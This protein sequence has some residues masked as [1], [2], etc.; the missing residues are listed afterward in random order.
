MKYFLFTSDPESYLKD[1]QYDTLFARTSK[2]HAPDHWMYIGEIDFDDSTD[3][4]TRTQE[5]VKF[6]DEAILKLRAEMQ[7]QVDQLETRKAN[8]LSLEYIDE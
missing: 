1:P 5:A 8:L 2:D 4:D 6:I 7:F 3:I